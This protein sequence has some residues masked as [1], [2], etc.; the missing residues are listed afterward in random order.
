MIK[1]LNGGIK[2]EI[3]LSIF[4]QFIRKLHNLDYDN[5]TLRM[6]LNSQLPSGYIVR[7]GKILLQN[8]N[9]GVIKQYFEFILIHKENIDVSPEELDF[10]IKIEDVICY[11]E[12]LENNSKENIILTLKKIQIMKKGYRNCQIIDK[13]TSLSYQKLGLY[14]LPF[15]IMKKKYQPYSVL[16]IKENPTEI[17][18]VT[19]F[20]LKFNHFMYH[21]FSLEEV[22]EEILLIDK[23]LIYL[24]PQLYLKTNN[25]PRAI[26]WSFTK[27]STKSYRCHICGTKIYRKHIF[28][29]FLCQKCGDLNYLKRIQVSDLKGRV[30]LVTGGRVRIGYGIGLKLLR[31]G[32]KVIILTRFPHNAALRYSKENDY[33]LWECNLEIYG[34]DF[35][36]IKQVTLF[37]DYIKLNYPYLDIIINNAAQTVRK[38]PIYF[39]HLITYERYNLQQLPKNIQSTLMKNWTFWNKFMSENQKITK[40]SLIDSNNAIIPMNQNIVN[41]NSAELSQIPLIDDD[42]IERSEGNFPLNQFDEYDEQLD[43]RTK[44]TWVSRLNEVSIPEILEVQVINS[45]VPTLIV[46]QFRE[47]LTKSPFSERFIINVSSAEG[48]FSIP[49]LEGRHPHTC[50]AKASLN[51]ITHS[52][53]EDYFFDSIYVNSVDPGWISEQFPLRGKGMM[54][55]KFVLDLEDAAARICDPIFIALN[56]GIYFRGMLLKHYRKDQ[57]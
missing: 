7:N 44:N 56:E 17:K 9:L 46:S 55:H 43:L 31:A 24:N 51:M 32:A 28:Y 54:K 50:I 29:D 15:N 1:L 21:H 25:Y 11:L 3:A 47:L 26:G 41:N 40:N 2:I 39:K 33:K 18:N 27:K 57:W 34:L 48:Q 20:C 53:A 4:L 35:R 8:K 22:P 38:P 30:A 19:E 14:E 52:I 10:E 42:I 13:V 36:N 37:I 23:S 45:I 49:K 6:K 12:I 16:I 5:K